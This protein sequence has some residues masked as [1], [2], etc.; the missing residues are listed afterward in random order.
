MLLLAIAATPLVALSAVVA[1]QSYAAA[2]DQVR[3]IVLLAREAASARHEAALASAARLVAS[4]ASSPGILARPPAACGAFLTQIAALEPDRYE[5]IAAIGADGSIR[6]SSGPAEETQPASVADQAWF[7]TLR[8]SGQPVNGML[9]SVAAEPPSAVR[10]AVVVAHAVPDGGQPKGFQGALAI[11]LRLDWFTHA[12]EV[13]P[14]DRHPAESWLVQPGLTISPMDGARPADLP[15][16]GGLADVMRAGSAVRLIPSAGGV[17]FAYAVTDLS[18]SLV[19]LSGF[20]AQDAVAPARKVLILRF[21]ALAVVVLAGFCIVAI[22]ANKAVADPVRTLTAAVRKWRTDAARG[23]PFQ[24]GRARHLPSEIVELSDAFVE[25]TTTLADREA[26]LRAAAGAQE[27]LMKEIHHRVKN[28]LQIVASLLNLQA[29]RI[30]LPAARAE[31]QSAR[32]RVRALATLHRH[33]YSEGELHSINMRGFLIELCGQLFQAMGEAEG[34][35]IH[36]EIEAPELAMSSD[37]ATPLSLIVTEAVSN[38][39]KYAFPDHRSGTISVRLTTG[40]DDMAT[41]VIQ[42]DGVGIP[43][44]RAETETGTRDGLGLQ[45]MGGFARQLGAELLVEQAPDGMPGTRY[46]VTLRLRRE[47]DAEAVPAAA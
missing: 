21:I 31:F 45:L 30:T 4:L 15:G 20:R 12:A 27:L 34:D 33:L 5:R 9:Q 40:A 39:L 47:R 24:A 2:G 7:K 44:G 35:R 26:K 41:L 22:G 17:L 23:E 10:D 38:S 19:M 25:T 3:E 11:F 13:V 32:D 6:C 43:A 37:Q 1:W 18:D 8:T 42:D 16:G 28:N 29:N 14:G 36:L 46:A